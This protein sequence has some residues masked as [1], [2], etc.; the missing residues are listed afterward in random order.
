MC[1]MQPVFFLFK[2]MKLMKKILESHNDRLQGYLNNSR[3]IVEMG[4][5]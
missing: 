3:D 2:T 1:F 5:K 4:V